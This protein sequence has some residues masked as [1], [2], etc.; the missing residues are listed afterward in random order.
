MNPGVAMLGVV[1][2]FLAGMLGSMDGY[3]RGFD[4]ARKIYDRPAVPCP[5]VTPSEEC[6]A[7]AD[8]KCERHQGLGS[9]SF[10]WCGRADR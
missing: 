9:V 1:A 2:L 5:N 4:V 3:R 10:V 6:Q 7:A 8:A